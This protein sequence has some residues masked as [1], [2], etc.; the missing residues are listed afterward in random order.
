MDYLLVR[1]GESL[2]NIGVAMNV[3]DAKVGLSQKGMLQTEATVKYIMEYAKS[4]NYNKIN[5]VFS[6]YE[7]TRIMADEL[8]KA[9]LI[10]RFREEPLVSEIQCGDFEGYTFDQYKELYPSEYEKICDYKKNGARFWYKY[11]NGESPFDVNIRSNLFFD[12]N[13]E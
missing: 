13:A 7:R 6:P 11:R 1:H 5:V 8:K 9:G 4:M 12:K 3:I 2:Q 10:A